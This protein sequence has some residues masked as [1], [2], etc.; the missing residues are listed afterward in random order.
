MIGQ[1][2]TAVRPPYN[3]L[4]LWTSAIALVAAF[5]GV[6]LFADQHHIDLDRYIPSGSDLKLY[7]WIALVAVFVLFVLG[8]AVGG[9]RFTNLIYGLIERL[10]GLKRERPR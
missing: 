10:G 7:F 1:A 9:A 8:N 4:K 5:L 6:S 2:G 3:R